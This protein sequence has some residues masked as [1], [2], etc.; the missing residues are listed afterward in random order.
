MDGKYNSVPLFLARS[1]SSL[2]NCILY[3]DLPFFSSPSL[4]TG[5]SL[6]SDLALNSLD[7]I[8][9]LLEL[10]VGFETYI[11]NKTSPKAAKYKPIFCDLNSNYRSIHVI[12]LSMS[13]LG[14]LNGG[15]FRF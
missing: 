4:I 5:D 8:L 6:K 13:A 1:Y 3:A 9:F 2:K 14:I 10:T 11:E 15:R 12:N 7:N